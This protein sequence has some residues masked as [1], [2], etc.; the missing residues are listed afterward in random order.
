[1]VRETTRGEWEQRVEDWK[2]SGLTQKEYCAQKGVGFARLRYWSARLHRD[3]KK[4]TL[5]PVRISTNVEVVI[6]GPRGWECVLPEGMSAQWVGLIC[7]VRYD[8]NGEDLVGVGV[9]G[10]ACR[11]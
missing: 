8:R 11:G 5:V 1:M 4:L 9:R 10:H 3:Q 7:C 6:R 2:A